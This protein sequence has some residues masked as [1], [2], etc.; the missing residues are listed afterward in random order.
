MSC[1]WISAVAARSHDHFWFREAENMCYDIRRH[2]KAAG[3]YGSSVCQTSGRPALRRRK[4]TTRNGHMAQSCRS[5]DLVSAKPTKAIH[6][7]RCQSGCRQNLL[8]IPNRIIMEI[9]YLSI[10]P[11]ALVSKTWVTTLSMAEVP[12]P[13]SNFTA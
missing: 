3:W 6:R 11:D 12:D 7:P 5:Q 2:E 4:A 13:D 9:R 1:A 8:Q 10:K